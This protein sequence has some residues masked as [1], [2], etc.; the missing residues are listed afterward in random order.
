MARFRAC[1]AP[2]R[3]PGARRI[4]HALVALAFLSTVPAL[5]QA[6]DQAP[7][8]RRVEILLEV[9][10]LPEADR[11]HLADRR[12]AIA[13]AKASRLPLWRSFDPREA[14]AGAL[15]ELAR[16]GADLGDTAI[17]NFD[18]LE[19]DV[20]ESAVEKLAALPFVRTVR[21][22]VIGTP[23]GEIDS[24][25]IEDLGIDLVHAM[26]VTGAGVKVAI[27]DSDWKS[28]AETI[29]AGDLPA[30][31][32]QFNVNRSTGAVNPAT[33]LAG[34]GEREHGTAAA[35]VVHE[36]VPD[37]QL[38]LYR[39]TR[40]ANLRL[41]AV[42]IQNAIR[43]AADQGAHVI[44]VPSH[45]ITT[46]SDP[47]GLDQGGTNPFTDDIEYATAAGST[48]VVA[49]GNEAVRHWS[50]KFTP[51]NGCTNND[52][53]TTA[54]NDKNFHI[55]DDEQPLNEITIE[56]DHLSYA[57]SE[58]G[59][60]NVIIRCYSATDAA[61]PTKFK[62]QLYRFHDSYDNPNPPDFPFC[63]HDAGVAGVDGTR[64]SL[65]DSLAK[66]VSLLGDE[67]DDY[68]YIAIER[69]GGTET[70]SFRVNCFVATGELW[71]SSPESSLSDLAV[72]EDSLS[73]AAGT[74]PS[75]DLVA[76]DSSQGP[77]ADPFGPIKP[78]ITG[79]AE[80][81][82]YAVLD[83]GFIWTETINGTSSAASH[84]AGIV[85]LLQSW[86][87]ENGLPPLTPDEVKATLF[88]HAIDI[89]E[90]G[91][92]PLS[93]NGLV[94]IP[95]Y[96][97]PEP[98]PSPTPSPTPTP[99]PSPTP[100]PEITSTPDVT[101]TP[102]GGPTVGPT[103]S[104]TPTPT[105]EP[106]AT[107]E[108]TEA[109]TP[110]PTPSPSASPSPEPTAD[111]TPAP[112]PG[113]TRDDFDGDRR[114]DAATYEGSTGIWRLRTGSGP[115]HTEI[116]FGVQGLKPVPA[117]YDGDTITDLAL[118]NPQTG[119]W[120]IRFQPLIP[121]PF[122]PQVVG[123]RFQPAPADYDGD[124][125][126]D[127]AVYDAEAP[128]GAVSWY[129][130]RSSDGQVAQLALGGAGFFAAPGDYDGDSKAD[131]AVYEKN[132]GK[133]WIVLSEGGTVPGLKFGNNKFR[134]VPGDYDGDNITDLAT[135]QKNKGRWR[136]RLSSQGGA[137]V[138]YEGFGGT[139]FVPVPGDY[140][141][142]GKTDPGTYKKGNGSWRYLSSSTGERTVLAQGFGGKGETPVVGMRPGK[143]N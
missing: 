130:K 18:S 34:T 124:K 89:E 66:S 101:P 83:A 17:I 85:A 69:I 9:D 4:V 136:I 74:W 109:P 12:Q 44:L 111:P 142:D 63:P 81:S 143:N 129:V 110:T 71:F 29:A 70:P 3:R 55:F 77:T 30:N 47:K 133:W 24:E 56:D 11:A 94:Q 138:N 118:H 141:A 79:P 46:M 6:A 84:V 140:D 53:C 86:Q 105:P 128:V 91:P 119:D 64:V 52:I 131:F 20:P 134:P 80:V 75:Y 120:L 114:A 23:T 60:R 62:L 99:T 61:D 7:A 73:V 48:V 32:Q 126:A 51:C 38:L 115:D 123:K 54:T 41:S 112:T 43:H 117:D 36:I 57:D 72:V 100:T 116:R 122:G 96:M 107:P 40:L 26:G 58:D 13:D 42:T 78:D 39:L 106:T 22:P 28:L 65:G 15:A 50:G 37:A 102:T 2:R 121:N 103:A 132:T 93:G 127:L 98:S 76:F 14:L 135:Y 95:T 10:R 21:E 49:A 88:E 97:L 82:N 35:E 8:T 16:H 1:V 19:V 68:Y 137:I 104:P 90:E 139:G 67:F 113:F 108:P 125:K 92:D 33:D 45:F 27:L 5:A 87:I 59:Y 31:T 25:A